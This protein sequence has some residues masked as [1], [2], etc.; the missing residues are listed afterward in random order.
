MNIFTRSALVLALL[1]STP[2]LSSC[3][4]DY[5]RNHASDW[6]AR[7]AEMHRGMM[8]NYSDFSC[9]MD[10][11]GRGMRGMPMEERRAWMTEHMKRMPPEVLKQRMEIMEMQLQVMRDYM[12]TQ[13]GAGTPR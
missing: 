6:E 5:G 1:A 12:A 10:G 2:F 9:P 8:G 3:A 7:H 4:T 11:P 13:P